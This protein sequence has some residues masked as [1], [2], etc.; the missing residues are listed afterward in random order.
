MVGISRSEFRGRTAYD[1]FMAEQAIPIIE[2]WN[3]EDV[4]EV[5]RKPWKRMNAQG[6]FVQLWGQE[7]ITAMYVLEI[8]PREAISVERHMYEET[9]LIISGAGS[10]EVKAPDGRW[11][12]FEWNEGALFAIPLNAEHRLINAT[13][14]PV[15]ALAQTNAPIMMDHFHNPRFVFSCDFDFTDRYDGGSDYF[16]ASGEVDIPNHIIKTNVVSDIRTAPFAEGYGRHR[17]RDFRSTRHGMAANVMTGHYA[18][19]PGGTYAKSHCHGGGA[20]LVIL[21]GEGYAL[22]WPWT[23]GIRPWEAGNGDK[24]VKADF[25]PY[26]LYSPGTGWFHTHLGTSHENVRQLALRYGSD[27]HVG[28]HRVAS[29]AGGPSVS[30]RE[31]GTLIDWDMEDPQLRKDF[32]AELERKGVPYRMDPT[33]AP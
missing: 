30:I 22:M 13:S 16:K 17:A 1:Q 23:A 32:K 27:Y 7:D 24:V 15:L 10:T 5:E 11:E 6:A 19:F 9:F 8:P 21:K 31:G 2:G 4:R 20:V 25:K 3:I 28:F 26:S 33:E 29:R 14:S 12:S 18:E